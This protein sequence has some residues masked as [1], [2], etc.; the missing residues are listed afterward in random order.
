MAARRAGNLTSI[1][2]PPGR[3]HLAAGRALEVGVAVL[4]LPRLPAARDRRE[5]ARAA[6]HHVRGRA[7]HLPRP[8]HGGKPRISRPVHGGYHGLTPL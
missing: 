7:V 6:G 8:V 3:A 5:L 1:A 4:A 2:I